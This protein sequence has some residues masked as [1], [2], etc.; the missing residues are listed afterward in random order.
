M[1]QTRELCQGLLVWRLNYAQPVSELK[2]DGLLCNSNQLQHSP[3]RSC[4][5][6][7]GSNGHQ[8][9]ATHQDN[10]LHIDIWEQLSSDRQL[11]QGSLSP[12]TRTQYVLQPSRHGHLSYQNCH[13]E[14]QSP[15]IILWGHHNFETRS[16]FPHDLLKKIFLKSPFKMTDNVHLNTE[17][18][19]SFLPMSVRPIHQWSISVRL[20]RTIATS[21]K[22]SA[23][24][25][26]ETL[27][28]SIVLRETI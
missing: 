15:K 28:G 1:L 22:N 21:C 26:I 11:L 13:W 10:P 2:Q 9:S 16:N 18:T 3:T 8:T 25:K 6:T 19:Y 23:W 24:M 12:A 14:S 17:F 20:P 5:V 27:Q 7:P 4:S